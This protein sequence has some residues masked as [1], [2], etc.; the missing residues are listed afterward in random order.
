MSPSFPFLTGMVPPL[1]KERLR[2]EL[3]SDPPPAMDVA[4]GRPLSPER[5]EEARRIFEV[6][7]PVG[8]GMLQAGQMGPLNRLGQF[9]NQ[10]LAEEN[11]GEVQEFIGEVGDMANQRF[12]V[13]LGSVGQRPMFNQLARPAVQMYEKGGQRFRI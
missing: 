5:L 6:G 11:Q 13:D 8:I 7:R 3:V 2:P 9:I 1:I 12:G 4:A 10:E